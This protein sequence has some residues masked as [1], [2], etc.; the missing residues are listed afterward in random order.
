MVDLE[1]G[2]VARGVPGVGRLPTPRS[3]DQSAANTAIGTSRLLVVG[4]GSAGVAEANGAVARGDRVMLVEASGPP[5][6]WRSPRTSDVSVLTR[7]TALG[8]YDDGFVVVHERSRPIERLW[9]VRASARGA[10]DRCARAADRVRGQRP[11]RRDARRRRRTL[12]RRGS[13]CCPASARSSSR[14]TTRDTTR[15]S[16]S[17]DAGV[18]IA[19]IVDVGAGGP[20]TDAAASPGHRRPDRLGGRRDRRRSAALHGASARTGRRTRTRST[21]TCCSCPAGGTRW[22]SSGGRSAAACATTS[23][24]RAS[25]RT[26]TVRD[27]LSVVGAAAG[28]VPDVAT[29]TGSCL[30]RTTRGTSSTSSATRRS[31]T[32][33][34]A[35][36]HDL[37]SV[38]HIKRATYIGTALDQGRTSGVLTAAIVNQALGAGPGRARPDERPA[39]VHARSRSR[40]SPGPT[41]ATCSIRPA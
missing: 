33:L 22:C 17:R 36:Q 40:R 37:R 19:A 39:T 11:A 18:E 9:H 38:E 30:P 10:R 6:G 7:A 23:R 1:E 31:P 35:V 41:A 15:R 2:L 13:A 3:A 28:E 26:G 34:D 25:S 21:P 24:G 16:R 8:V 32:S 4:G 14:R 27:W 5:A 12:R 20:A 29:R